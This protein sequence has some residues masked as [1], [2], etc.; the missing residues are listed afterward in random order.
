MNINE[1]SFCILFKKKIC[2]CTYDSIFTYTDD[3]D[4]DDDD[5]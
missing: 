5:L 3:D 4:D 2:M 1:F